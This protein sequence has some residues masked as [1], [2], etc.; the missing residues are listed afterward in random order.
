[1]QIPKRGHKQNC[2]YAKCSCERCILTDKRR[3]LMIESMRALRKMAT[4]PKPKVVSKL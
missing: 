3:T 1:M 4:L 2:I